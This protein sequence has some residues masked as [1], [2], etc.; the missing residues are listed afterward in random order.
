MNSMYESS[1]K[2]SI[3][4]ATHQRPDHLERLLNALLQQSVPLASFEV[5]IVDNCVEMDSRV[6]DLLTREPF[7]LLP[8]R[9]IHQPV[10]G[11]SVSRNCGVAAAQANLVG[12]LDDDC[13]PPSIWV[14]RIVEDYQNTNALI[15]GGPFA[16]F[17]T[18]LKPTWFRDSYTSG[19]YGEQARWLNDNE[20]LFGGNMVWN[21]ELLKRLGGF[22]LDFGPVGRR[23]A[24]GEDTELHYRASCL[25]IRTWYDPALAV[26]HH[27]SLE[28]M[29]VRWLMRKSW[30]HAQA[31]AMIFFTNL[32]ARDRRPPARSALS[33]TIIALKTG[34]LLLFSYLMLLWRNRRDYPYWQN[35]VVERINPQISRLG[36]NL[37][38]A[39]LF[40][41]ERGRK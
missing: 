37:R 31:K 6:S 7:H 38:L 29:S 40:I 30:R 3:V 8:L 35:Y 18:S 27:T 20:F 4:I 2:L 24:M 26:Q 11:A 33:Y 15:I 28:R 25:G 39:G 14:E 19:Q 16:P 41:Q 21:K 34:V 36:L 12:F 23:L 10:L 22:S 1:L 5:I 17:Y 13:I 32:A 9:Y